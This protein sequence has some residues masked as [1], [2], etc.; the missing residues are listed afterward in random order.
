MIKSEFTIIDPKPSLL[1]RII[2]AF[3]FTVFLAYVH[4]LV[5]E[6]II[7]QKVDLLTVI[8]YMVCIVGVILILTIGS[9]SRH[10]IQFSFKEMKIR[11]FYDISLFRH[12]EKW[13]ALQDLNYLSIYKDDGK[14]NIILWYDEH[15]FLNLFSMKS[16]NEI[17]KNACLIANGLHIEVLDAT[18]NDAFNHW[19]DMEVF[20]TTGKIEHIN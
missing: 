19:I 10:G 16:Y 13:Q 11:H 6:K 1:K 5:R 15:N 12:K 20:K 2:V 3:V 18:I 17:V 14:Y 9:I 7:I 4:Y 8:I